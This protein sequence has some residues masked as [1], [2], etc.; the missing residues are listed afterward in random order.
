MAEAALDNP[1]DD[2]PADQ[3]TGTIADQ[4]TPP[5]QAPVAPLAADQNAAPPDNVTPLFPDDWREQL[6]E[7]DDKL[8]KELKRFTSPNMLVKSWKDARTKI[9][10][11]QYKMAAPPEGATEDQI[12]EWRQQNG[13][14]E[15]ADKYST[16]IGEGMVLGEDDMA[17]V[18]GFLEHAHEKN[19]PQ[20]SVT[21]MLEWYYNFNDSLKSQVVARDHEFRVNATAEL[22]NQWGAEYDMNLNAIRALVPEEVSDLLFNARTEDGE[23]LGSHPRVL[24]FLA[25]TAREMYPEATVIP[26]GG[27]GSLDSIETEIAAIRK[28]IANPASGYYKDQAK[29]DR[30]ARLLEARDK[31]SRR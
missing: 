11:G 8:L 21:A 14:P 24:Q 30:F 15:S 31:L 26:G 16:D 17:I 27:T 10:S 7:G 13:I 5:T 25:Q 29:Q 1:V 22:K 20:S 2:T 9:S 18:K 23:V 6:A 4:G 12:A 19:L 28:D 3:T